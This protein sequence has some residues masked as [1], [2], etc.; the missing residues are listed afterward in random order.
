ME[1][2]NLPTLFWFKIN[3]T[4]SRNGGA[5]KSVPIRVVP[6][7]STST[8][9]QWAP[10]GCDAEGA[11]FTYQTIFRILNSEGFLK[12]DTVKFGDNQIPAFVINYDGKLTYI[13]CIS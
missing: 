4:V 3:V 13:V 10:S 11:K 1:L 9:I 7:G 2:I 6:S 12:L 5:C 8:P